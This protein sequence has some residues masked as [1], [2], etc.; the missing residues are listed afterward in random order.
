M[1]LGCVHCVNLDPRVT[2][3]TVV[4][5]QYYPGFPISLWYRTARTVQR[6]LI[7]GAPT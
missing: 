2:P 1:N 6:A 3:C 7:S 5:G 4:F